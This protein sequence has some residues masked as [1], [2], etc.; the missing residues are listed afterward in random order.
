MRNTLVKE[1]LHSEIY[2][3]GLRRQAVALE[4]ALPPIG[5]H[6]SADQLT[7]MHKSTYSLDGYSM[8]ICV[9]SMAQPKG[10]AKTGEMQWT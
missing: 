2:R 9:A 3:L 8:I 1:S 7:H 10:D 4:L 6:V 5:N